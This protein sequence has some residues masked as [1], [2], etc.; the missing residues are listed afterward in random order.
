[1]EIIFFFK[2]HILIIIINHFLGDISKNNYMRIIKNKLPQIKK[3]FKNTENKFRT[4]L[5]S[6]HTFDL[7]Y[8]LFNLTFFFP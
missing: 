5:I 8:F 4:F 6:K 3:Y 7:I 1:M 2:E